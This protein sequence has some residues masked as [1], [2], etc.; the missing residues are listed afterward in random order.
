MKTKYSTMDFHT[1]VRVDLR[2]LT[3][4]ELQTYLSEVSNRRRNLKTHL[5]LLDQVIRD[6]QVKLTRA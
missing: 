5:E 2:R 6:I 1:L 4:S 3:R